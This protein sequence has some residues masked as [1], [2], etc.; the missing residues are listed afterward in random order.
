M[1]GRSGSG[2]TEGAALLASGR[3]RGFL[4]LGL[5][6]GSDKP[7]ALAGDGADQ[8]LLLA[9]V[10]QGAA[11]CI[12]AARERR[13]RHDAAVPDR[14]EQI[15]ARHHALAIAHQKIDEIEHLRLDRDQRVRP[16]QLAPLRIEHEILKPKRQSF[17]P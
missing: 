7:H 3:G 8:A 4:P 1:A 10:V 2:N 15:V 11:G 14:V 9:G 6:D 16:A 17:R 5:L 13:F 12:D